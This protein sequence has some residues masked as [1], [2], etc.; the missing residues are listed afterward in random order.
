MARGISFTEHNVDRTPLGEPGTRKA[1]ALDLAKGVK[2]IWV[3]WGKAIIHKNLESEPISPGDLRRYL[4]HEDGMM[5]VPV[6]I[7]GDTLIRGYLPDM[8]EQVLSGFQSR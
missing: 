8:Y 2:W 3:K 7:L 4:I 5:R 1:G 6:L